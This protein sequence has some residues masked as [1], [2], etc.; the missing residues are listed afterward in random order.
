MSALVSTIP[1]PCGAFMPV[2]VIGKK[3]LACVCVC[4]CVKPV[5]VHVSV[6]QKFLITVEREDQYV[7]P[8]SQKLSYSLSLVR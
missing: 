2:F 4:V 7:S 1:V 5:G 8:A 3:Q 6:R